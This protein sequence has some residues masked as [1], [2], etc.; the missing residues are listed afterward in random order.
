MFKN[1]KD[2]N[3][4]EV[5]SY[6]QMDGTTHKLT[7]WVTDENSASHLVSNEQG[8]FEILGLDAGTYYLKEI[9][10]PTGYNIMDEPQPVVIS[11][12]KNNMENNSG[13]DTGESNTSSD[14]N[15]VDPKTGVVN[16]EVKNGKGFE[17]PST[18]AIGQTMIYG[19]G[20]LLAIG[21]LSIRVI[22][23]RKED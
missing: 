9:K 18:G 23:H 8:E 16:A 4:N 12:T 7:Q 15:T 2:E 21:G 5:K 17:M 13:D 19:A 3:G 1:T 11:N 20:A 14:T 22:R 6:A 10:A